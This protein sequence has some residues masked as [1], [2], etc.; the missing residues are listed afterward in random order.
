[1]SPRVNDHVHIRSVDARSPGT[2]GQRDVARENATTR[3]PH[4][5]LYSPSREG[6]QK[7]IGMFDKVLVVCVGNICRSPMAE[8]LLRARLG[9]RPRFD[10]SSAGVSALVGRPADEQ[11]VALMKARGIDIRPHRAR[12]LT[13]QLAAGA[14][15]I[16]VMESGHERAV[17]S[18]APQTRGKV[19]RIGRFGHFDVPDPYRL[20][21]ATFLDALQ[22]VE[23]G[24][25]DY[26]RAFW[27]PTLRKVHG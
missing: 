11:A 5:I 21:R 26:E 1:M 25:N 14:D 7:R 12:Q 17:Y 15:L 4:G 3:Y 10:V 27:P 22:L 13:P 19:H 18:I 20:P 24:I 9:H 16:L 23:R 2:Q 8:A 6:V